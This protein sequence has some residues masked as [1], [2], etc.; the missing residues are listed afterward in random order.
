MSDC[1]AL[2]N[3]SKH[4]PGIQALKQIDFSLKV[5]ESHCLVGENGS[6]KSTLIKIM[7]GV[8]RPTRCRDLC[9]RQF[10]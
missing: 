8:I 7:S 2:R 1:I 4:Y 9:E 6:G 10:V 3:V 5:G